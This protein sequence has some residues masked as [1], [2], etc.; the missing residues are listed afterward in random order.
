[1]ELLRFGV[2]EEY[3]LADSVSR[4]TVARAAAVLTEAGVTLGERA[5]PEFIATQVEGCTPPVCTAAELRDA[6]LAV[7]SVF[8]VAARRAGCLLVASGTAVL[9]SVHPLPVTD[10]ARYRRIAAHVGPGIAD[11]V[12]GELGGCHIHVG[13][14]DRPSALAVQARLRPWLP[15]LESVA[16][17]SPFC[18]GLHTGS[19]SSRAFRY[20]NWPT[21]GPA[22]VVDGPGYEDWVEHALAEGIMLDRRSLYWYARPSEHLPTVEIRMADVNADVD[23]AVL[24]AV[25][26]RGMTHVL[27]EELRSGVP[28]RSGGVT[29][30]RLRAAHDRAA[31]GGLAGPGVDPVTGCLRPWREQLG[32][33]VRRATPG[34]AM[35]GDLPLA[36]R[37]AGKLVNG[38]T[39]AETQRA[40]HARNGSLAEVVDHLAAATLR[41]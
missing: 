20:A 14:L 33:L 35:Y 22:P 3:L 25:L 10:W 7:R 40:V 16:V 36:E 26:L 31:W 17:N 21:V 37:L 24:L 2:E 18:E 38:R 4:V 30:R 5:Q 23:V 12:G 32:D 9:P 39:G 13:D 27:L 8:G 29:G 1:M 11:Q 15:V 41:G 6:L 34:L 19:S 28:D